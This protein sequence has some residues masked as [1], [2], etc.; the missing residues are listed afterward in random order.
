MKNEYIYD[1]RS[2][3][4]SKYHFSYMYFDYWH[5]DKRG[6]EKMTERPINTVIA[7]NIQRYMTEKEIKLTKL[8]NELGT[9]TTDTRR[10]LNGGNITI[11]RLQQIAQVLGVKTIDLVEDWKE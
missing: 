3:N 8:A 11:I 2:S 6:A 9:S 5:S 7:E 4:I 10:I 1:M